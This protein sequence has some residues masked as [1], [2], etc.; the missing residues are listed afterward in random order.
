MD[1]SRIALQTILKS[2]VTINDS[3]NGKSFWSRIDTA[4]LVH[5]IVCVGS[6]NNLIIN[7]DKTP[8][9]IGT[10]NPTDLLHIGSHFRINDT[11]TFNNILASTGHEQEPPSI[12]VSKSDNSGNS[13]IFI[14]QL[15][16]QNVT[17]NKNEYVSDSMR[18]IAVDNAGYVYIAAYAS[19]SQDGTANS[20]GYDLF[21]LKYLR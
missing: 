21:L 16:K 5:E 7:S 13:D 3:S 19:G 11:D 15:D 18:G 20:G 17:S 14:K 2:L 6:T 10:T 8:V 9:G 4:P 1:K 12:Q